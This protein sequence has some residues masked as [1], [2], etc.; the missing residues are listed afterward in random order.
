MSKR[1]SSSRKTRNEHSQSIGTI[2]KLK[3]LKLG[4]KQGIG[5]AIILIIMAGA[6]I[7]SARKMAEIKAEID[8]VT[9]SWLPRAI[10]ISAIN[11]N[12]ANL[13]IFQLQYVIATDETRKEELSITVSSLIDTLNENRDKYEKL[14][15]S[16]ED[17]HLYSEN[18][19]TLYDEFDQKWDDYQ[20]L[21]YTIIQLIR[22]N[23]PEAAVALLN[24]EAQAVFNDLSADLNELVNINKQDSFDAAKRADMTYQSAHNIMISLYIFT[25]LLSVFIATRLARSIIGPVQQLEQAAGKVARGDLAVRL[26]MPGKDEIGNLAQSFNQMTSSLQEAKEKTRLQADKLEARNQ[27]LGRTMY[28]LKKTQNELLMKEKMASLGD[29]VAGIAHEINNPIGV[30]ISS[31]D[32]SLR[33]LDKIEI[34]LEKSETTEKRRNNNQLPEALRILKDNIKNILT[35]GD[36]IATIVKSM[37]NFARLDEADYQK[38]DLHEGLDSSLTLLGTELTNR[39]EIVKEYGEIPRIECYPG[40][41]NQVF[42]SLLKNASQAIEDSGTIGIKTY[43]TKNHIH[44]QISD[45]GKGIPHEKLNKIFNFNFSAAGSRIKMA[46]GLTTAYNIIQKHNGEI[47]VKSEVGKGTTF[48]IILPIK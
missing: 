30:M 27:D 13:H 28:Q 41:L 39:L 38:V 42:I 10:A 33:C 43:K 35:A 18:E 3:D 44:V 2:I 34:A 15:D 5:F 45:T 19:R 40:Q 48:S 9:A 7:Y 4:T 11:I 47:K 36:R 46:A 32:V 24:G 12:T 17:R 22:D 16:A 31:T 25:L 37:K 6:H 23:E 26:D 21:T 14:R 1:F 29:L 20:Y 8:E